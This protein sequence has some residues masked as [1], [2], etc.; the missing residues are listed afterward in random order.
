MRFN[1]RFVRCGPIA[2]AVRYRAVQ[3]ILGGLT[4]T[5]DASWYDESTGTLH[6]AFPVL[7][8]QVVVAAPDGRRETYETWRRL[9]PRREGEWQRSFSD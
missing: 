3:T 2:H 7:P 5:I 8:S 6:V 9:A 4:V 1:A